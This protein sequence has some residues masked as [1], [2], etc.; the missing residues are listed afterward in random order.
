[1]LEVL[2]Q[3]RMPKPHTSWPGRTS[4]FHHSLV[5]PRDAHDHEGTGPDRLSWCL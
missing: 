2:F 4:S 3:R 5:G 1:M